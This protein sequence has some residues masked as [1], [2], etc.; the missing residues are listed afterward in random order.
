MYDANDNTLIGKSRSDKY[1]LFQNAKFNY[2]NEKESILN[3][4]DPA[5][6]FGSRGYHALSLEGKVGFWYIGANKDRKI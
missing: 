3:L 6:Y 5:R 4:A 2:D 1:T